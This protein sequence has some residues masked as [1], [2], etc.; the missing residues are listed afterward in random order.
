[1]AEGLD[2]DLRVLGFAT[3][4]VLGLVL[5]VFHLNSRMIV[6]GGRAGDWPALFGSVGKK[7]VNECATQAWGGEGLDL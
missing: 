2:L 6:L 5:S 7:T 3:S 4:L 1:M